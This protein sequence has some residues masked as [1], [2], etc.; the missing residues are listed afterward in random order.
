M[1]PEQ[2]SRC[3]RT[4]AY[5]MSRRVLGIA[6]KLLS[7]VSTRR[8]E[9]VKAIAASAVIAL[10]AFAA[11][12]SQ[13]LA[14]GANSTCSTSGSAATCSGV[15]TGGISYNDA[16][17]SYVTVNAP[18]GPP[19]NVSTTGILVRERGNFGG[20]GTDIEFT[21]EYIDNVNNE[22]GSEGPDGIP[23]DANNDG[24]PDV[25]INGDGIVDVDLDGDGL[26]DVDLDG[27]GIPDEDATD[28]S[29]ASAAGAVNLI[30]N[31]SFTANG[32]GLHA[33]AEGGKGGK[34]GTKTVLGLYTKGKKGGNGN[35][36]GSVVVTNSGEIVIVGASRYGVFAT[37]EGGKGGNGGGA[38]GLVAEPGAGGRGGDG[39]EVF[40]DLKASSSI[41]TTGN[42]SHGVLAQSRGGDGGEGGDSDGAVALGSKGGNGGKGGKVTVN[43][44]GDITTSGDAAYGIFARSYGAGAGSGSDSGGIYAIGGNGGSYADGSAVTVTNTGTITTSGAGSFGVI[45]QSVGGG[46]GDGGSSGGVFATGGRAGSGGQGAAVTVTQGNNG[47]IATTGDRAAALVAQSIGGGGGNGGNATSVSPSSAVS[48]GGSGGPGGDG[49]TVTVTAGGVLITAG[50]EANAILA[51]SIGGGGGNGGRSISAGFSVGTGV[52][53]SV[54]VGGSGGDGGDGGVV[55]LTANA[56]IATAGDRSSGIVAQSIG[57][58]GGNGGMGIAGSI[59]AGASASVGVGGAGGKGGSASNVTVDVESGVILTEGVGSYGIFAQSVGGG[60]GSGGLSVAASASI[61]GNLNVALGGAGGDGGTGAAVDVSNAA[62]IETLG[63]GAYG[64][65]AQSIGG[66]GGEGGMSVAAG[67]SNTAAVGISVGGSGGSGNNGGTVNVDNTGRIITRGAQAYGI[68]AQSVG[69]GGGAGGSSIAASG[70]GGVAA[71]SVALGFGGS[72]GGGGAG[73][74]VTLG[75]TGDVT[76]GGAGSS[77]LVAQSV[78]GSGGTG[79]L[80]VAGALTASTSAG[81]AVSVGLGGNGGD[82]GTAGTVTL[83]NSGALSASGDGASGIVAQSLGGAGGIAG[84]SVAGALNISGGS[85]ASA[86]VSLGGSGGTGGTA[87][88][89]SVSNDGAIYTSGAD[90]YGVL[91]QSIGGSGG[92]GGLSVAGALNGTSGSGGSAAVSLGG[93]GGEGGRGGSVNITNNAI[94]VTNGARAIGV[95]AQSI[96]GDG[97]AGGLSVGLASSGSAS[98]RTGSA[99]VSLGGSGGDGGRGGTV[100]LTNNADIFSVGLAEDPESG[101]RINTD[102]YGLLAQSIGGSGGIGGLGGSAAI[103]LGSSGAAAASVAIGGAGGDGGRG[104]TVDLAN[105]GNIFTTSDRSHGIVAQSIGGNGGAGGASVNLSF[106]FTTS[107]TGGAAGASV[108]GSGG[109]GGVSDRV[110]VD[111]TGNVLTTGDMAYGILAQSVG[112]NGGAGG[113]SINASGSVTRATS[114]SI[115]ISLGGEGGNGGTAGDVIVGS[116]Q[117]IDGIIATTGGHSAAIVAQSIGGSGGA[118]GFSG[119]LNGSVN[120]STGS[121]SLAPSVT[122]GGFGG[123]GGRAGTVNVTTASTAIISTTGD[124]AYGILAQSVGGNGGNGGGALGLALGGGDSANVSLALGGAGGSGAI[125]NA[126]SVGNDGLIITGDPEHAD[127]GQ[128]AHGILAQSIGGSGGAGGF[129]GSFTFGVTNSNMLSVSVGGFGGIGND[130]GLVDVTNNGDIIVSGEHA[131]G[132]LAQSI[133]GGG[134]AGGDSG[135]FSGGVGPKTQ[136]LALS[137][138]GFGG[139]GGDGDKVDVTNAGSIT[140]LGTHGHAI[141]A[142]SIGGGGGKGGISTAATAALNAAISGT[143]SLTLGGF[144]GAGGDADTVTVTN[145]GEIITAYH[146]AYGVYAQSVGGGGGDGGGSRGFSVLHHDLSSQVKPGKQLAIAVGGFAG[147]GGDGGDVDVENS[148]LILTQSNGSVGIF[149]QSIGGGGG[150]GGSSSVGAKELKTKFE[151]QGTVKKNFRSQKYKL[152]VGGFGARGGAAGTV[153]ISN[154]GN[155]GT[156]GD[157]ATG[158]YAQSVGGGGGAG[159]LSGSALSGDISIGGYGG[160]ASDGGKVVVS[161]TGQI[162]TEGHLANGIF[163]QSVGGGGGDGGSADLGSA[164]SEFRNEFIKA[165]RKVGFNAAVQETQESSIKPHYGISVGGVGG[166]AGDGDTVTV[167]NGA[168]YDAT[169][170]TCSGAVTEVVIVTSGTASHGIFAQSVGGG[171]GVGGNAHL[172]NGGKTAIGGLGGAAGDGGDVTVVQRGDIVTLGQGSYGIFAQ[173]VGGGGGVAGD[174]TYGVEKTGV[175]ETRAVRDTSAN[176]FD[177]EGIDLDGDGTLTDEEKTETENLFADVLDDNGLPIS[178][179]AVANFTSAFE[180]LPEAIKNEILSGLPAEIRP[181]ITNG[182]D[183]L[184]YVKAYLQASSTDSVVFKGGEYG[185]RDG[186]SGDGGNVTVSSEG[187]II[188]M[189][190]MSDDPE[191]RAGSIGIFAQSVGGGGGIV[192]NTQ[193]IN[194]AEFDNNGDGDFDDVEDG[195]DLNGDGDKTDIVEVA[196]GTAFAGSTGGEGKGGEVSVSHMGS[197]YAPSWN[198]YGIFAQSVGGDGGSNIIVNVDEGTIQGGENMG[199]AIR[200]DGG[201]DNIITIGADSTIHAVSDRAIMATDGNDAV[202]SAGYVIGNI[203]LGLGANRYWNKTGGVLET[204]DTVNLNGGTLTND[205]DLVIAGSDNVGSTEFTGDFVQSAG[206]SFHVDLGFGVGP[207]ASDI[208]LAAGAADVS[209]VIVPTLK[210]FAAVRPAETVISAANGLT[211]NGVTVVDSAAVDYEVFAD[212]NDLKVGIRNVDFT[213]F[214]GLTASQASAG[215]Y[216]ERI[217]N[218]DGSPA[219]A[220]LFAFL[221]NQQDPAVI[222]SVM[223]RMSHEPYTAK[224]TST[225]NAALNFTNQLMSCPVN[226][227]GAQGTIKEGQ[228]YWAKAS[229]GYTS[230]DGSN[231]SSG[232]NETTYTFTS[233]MQVALDANWRAGLAIGYEKSQINVGNLSRSEGDSGS[234]GGVLKFQTGSWIL[235]GGITAGH[236]WYDTDRYLNLGAILPGAD[237]ANANHELSHANLR[238]RAANVVDL[239]AR[240]YLKPMV[241][242]NATYLYQHGFR[243]TGAGALNLSVEG[244]GR[245]LFSATPAIELGAQLDGYDGY[246]IRPFLRA[247]VTLFGDDLFASNASLEGAP[248]SAGQF[249]AESETDQI[250]GEFSAG[251]DILSKDDTFDLKLGYDG[252]FGDTLETHIGRVNFSTRF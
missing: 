161:N 21:V 214:D 51:Q 244:D 249:S 171:G 116:A 34:G 252:R 204:R 191:Q 78:G 181:L 69:G 176:K 162:V 64:I 200:L 93:P 88:T 130:A 210:S 156:M 20:D 207:G 153:D 1:L 91:A 195:L 229:A 221:A 66:G 118:G 131:V 126:V 202:E 42:D 72:G 67:L 3:Q 102:A 250:V 163:A 12:T 38:G 104:G 175:D 25:D 146:G 110:A 167:C 14:Q 17:F 198:G 74:T 247:G 233:G 97:G 215:A 39:G 45:A 231:G 203:D 205:G 236:G 147:A 99:S 177:G 52:N 232:V 220:S 159:G 15:P 235:A 85:G 160:A 128:N 18:A 239:G 43:N 179:E 6:P 170:G 40:V 154:S 29:N 149:G 186:I 132:I 245:W 46:G 92:A 98:A 105:L 73:G 124:F 8:L 113:F 26:P 80:A 226:A 199:A 243:E 24:L 36:G 23:D 68:L 248:A 82:G 238:L 94:I 108:G 228:C 41:T 188:A 187:T 209:G 165:I 109:N 32:H 140:T 10:L 107:G 158:I 123:D 213:S 217:L 172:A 164:S 208:L 13:A 48:V 112:G 168:A 49:G 101:E 189:G 183:Y 148:A 234:I 54:A 121:R 184:E 211:A 119:N 87:G 57:G 194:E 58:G 33:E 216:I 180:N 70:A 53:T 65:L 174:I 206:A 61:G 227:P 129:S 173:S 89:V 241:D 117:G 76:T 47:V 50:N 138:G 79:G 30:N 190:G 2:H 115:G 169:A 28:G 136:S 197:I 75:N 81:G 122:I 178:E 44:A 100:N 237:Q 225:V 150:A 95:A 193:A 142:Q 230:I 62:S 141:Q 212:G 111:S 133:G 192:S 11:P 114:G 71:G 22:D 59:S 185:F 166:A 63:D 196:D 120:T 201:A 56:L 4:V 157:G 31:A 152:S 139:A 86:G 55:D 9:R 219:L 224:E 144:G 143:Y 16:G 7:F 77:A 135:S 134:G 27:D 246:Q 106:A 5:I 223:E 125:G 90:A 84:I 103:A 37:S 127:A 83:I 240:L 96:G 242:L 60:G 155:I 151:A 251:I 35:D 182:D 137:V 222:A 145:S 218:G 19:V